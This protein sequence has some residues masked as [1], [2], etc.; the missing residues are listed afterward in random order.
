[1]SGKLDEQVG[2]A[3]AMPAIYASTTVTRRNKPCVYAHFAIREYGSFALISTLC[4][5]AM[6]SSIFSFWHYR[7]RALEIAAKE[8]FNERH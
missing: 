7:T 5:H 1:V 4:E 3:F 6:I 2:Y 8:Y